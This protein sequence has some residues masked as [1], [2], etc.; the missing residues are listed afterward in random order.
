[1]SID[2]VPAMT[3]IAHAEATLQTLV[4]A[5]NGAWRT[6]CAPVEQRQQ[7]FAVAHLIDLPRREF[8][9]KRLGGSLVLLAELAKVL[10]T[11][12]V[13]FWFV[14][15]WFE[16]VMQQLNVHCRELVLTH[17][18]RLQWLGYKRGK[19]NIPSGNV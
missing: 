13:V 11:P 7:I 16:V 8:F 1:M 15:F 18:V 2:H 19:M 3:R 14:V 12:F 4:C 5:S 17:T 6:F 10:L 9:C